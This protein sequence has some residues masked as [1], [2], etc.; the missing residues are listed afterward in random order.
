MKPQRLVLKIGTNVL[1]RPNGKLDYNQISEFTQLVAEIRS[2]KHEV[3]IISSGAV[4]AGRELCQYDSAENP[5]I[6]K[7]ILASV[8]QARLMQIYT[9]FL[10]EHHLTI[11]QVLLTRADFGNRAS[12]LNIRNTLTHL[13]EAGIVPIINENDV[14]A[15]EEL[16][17]NFGDNDWLAVYVAGLVDAN[18]LFYLTIAPGLLKLSDK[19]GTGEIIPEIRELN[20]E[21]LD[22]CFPN[23]SVGGRG[24]ME[25]KARAAGLA[26]NFGIDCHILDGKEP[27]SV[28]DVLSGKKRGTHFV[29]GDKK[30]ASYQKWLA[31]GALSQGRVKI[32]SGAEKALIVHKKSLLIQGITEVEGHFESKEMVELC[33]SD[34]KRIGVG[35]CHLSSEE[36]KQ[37]LENKKQISS[38]KLRNQKAIIHRD[39]LYLE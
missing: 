24:G 10:R 23:Q 13:L 12:Y 1:Q 26:M 28:M 8:G 14:V 30:P 22:H 11:A 33:N 21:V 38:E 18:R 2:Q 5:L 4:G 19:N 27:T 34:G 36:L 35:R 7:Q 39:H 6:Q 25:S 31:A 17:L 3:L 9:D 15:T 29:A 20:Q 37:F 16:T 32:D